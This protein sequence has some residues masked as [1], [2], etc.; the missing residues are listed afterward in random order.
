LLSLVEK[1]LNLLVAEGEFISIHHG[2]FIMR[3][4]Y[5]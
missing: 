3:L 1:Y 4:F 5:F 2:S